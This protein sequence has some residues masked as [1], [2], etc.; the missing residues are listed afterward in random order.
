LNAGYFLGKSTALATFGTG[1]VVL[2][3]A[4]ISILSIIGF[5]FTK[6]WTK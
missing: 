5:G 2:G 6:G 3:G 4:A 1:S